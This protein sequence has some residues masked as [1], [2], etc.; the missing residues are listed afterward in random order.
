ME[1][2]RIKELVAGDFTLPKNKKDLIKNCG[3]V[4]KLA[5]LHRNKT[6]GWVG[7]EVSVGPL[8]LWPE[9]LYQLQTK[10]LKEVKEILRGL[11]I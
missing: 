4:A 5:Q 6:C 9:I 8:F 11:D 2:E 3:V 7:K 1:A 10:A